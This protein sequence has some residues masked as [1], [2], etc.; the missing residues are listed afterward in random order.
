MHDIISLLT[1]N[2]ILA[3]LSYYMALITTGKGITGPMGT[4]L[5]GMLWWTNP[6]PRSL[7]ILT[8]ISDIALGKA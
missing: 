2:G 4:R 7:M 6:C 8:T 5:S 1:S 3:W